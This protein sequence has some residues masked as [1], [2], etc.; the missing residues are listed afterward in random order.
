GV[1]A[2]PLLVVE[3]AGQDV[4]QGAHGA[5][6]RRGV[7]AAAGLRPPPLAQEALVLRPAFGAGKDAE[8]MGDALHASAWLGAGRGGFGVGRERELAGH[9]GGLL[10]RVW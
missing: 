1:A 7:L 9:R 2:A 6:G 3:K 5:G 4:E 10:P 8:V